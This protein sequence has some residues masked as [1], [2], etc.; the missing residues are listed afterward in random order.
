MITF[1]N[2][3]LFGLSYRIIVYLTLCFF[4]FFHS[5]YGNLSPLS[6]QEFADLNFYLGFSQGEVFTFANFFE[7]YKRIFLLDFIEV[8]SRY[9]GP[10]FPLLLYFTSYKINFTLALSIIIF[11]FEISA[12]LIWSFK[13]YANYNL[14]YLFIFSVMPIP[15][16]YGFK[17]S[18][19]VIFYLLFTLFYFEITNKCRNKYIFIIYCL[20]ACLRPNS[21]LIFISVIFYIV[22]SKKYKK[23]LSL[24]CVFLLITTFY[25]SPYFLYEMN[26]LQISGINNSILTI[27]DFFM[28]IFNY[29]KKVIF[30]LG[31]APSSSGST[32]FYL[33]RCFCGVIFLIGFIKILYER[34]NK[35]DLVFVCF[36]VLG[37]ATLFFPAYRYIIPITPILILNFC[38]LLPKKF[39]N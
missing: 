2:I 14:F 10:L 12:Y 21:A 22:I 39:I 33:L 25:Y 38:Y 3:I 35:L 23:I 31:F 4:P 17:H 30:L 9:P 20:L 8:D 11:L 29:F 26:K 18:T 5:S 7:N 1:K 32:I 24:T 16:Y 6:Y 37:S 15:L 36:F 13:K 19:D 28:F 34:E 27:E